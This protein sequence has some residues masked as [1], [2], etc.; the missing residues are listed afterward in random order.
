MSKNCT[1]YIQPKQENAKDEAWKFELGNPETHREIDKKIKRVLKGEKNFVLIGGPP[2]QAYSLVG[3]AR[4]QEKEGLNKEDERVYL[5]REYYR[6][7]AEHSPQ[8]L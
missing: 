3:R 2:C 8:F 7:L 5:Y 4:R 6:I 1:V